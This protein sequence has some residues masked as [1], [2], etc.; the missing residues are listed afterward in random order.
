MNE[1][2]IK[3]KQESPQMKNTQIEFLVEK[4]VESDLIYKFMVGSEGT[5]KNVKDFSSEPSFN[6]VPNENGKYIIKNASGHSSAHVC[7]RRQRWHTL[8]FGRF[9][10]KSYLP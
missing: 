10:R 2:S 6:W 1:I 3:C 5:W 4:N 7:R 8:Y 9:Y